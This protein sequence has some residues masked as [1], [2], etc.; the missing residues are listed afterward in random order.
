MNLFFRL[1]YTLLISRFRKEVSV[2]GPCETP[3]RCLPVD[4]DVLNHM[5]NGR[6]LSLM[7]VARVDL[8]IRAGLYSKLN[9]KGYFPVVVAE[10]IR[11][12]KAINP[13]V[14]F[15]IETSVI[16]WDEKAFILK[17]RFCGDKGDFAEAVVRARFLKKSGGS[18][19]PK[20]IMSLAGLSWESPDLD[21]WIQEWNAINAKT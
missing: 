11:F 2:L 9:E 10:T 16:G 14:K 20:E 7:D 17:Q 13:F 5:N 6:Y 8:M 3:F 15:N 18:V 1:F 4:L 12:K 19:T 21:P